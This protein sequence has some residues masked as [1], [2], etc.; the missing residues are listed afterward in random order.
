MYL[1]SVFPRERLVAVVAREWLHGEVNPF[2]TRQIVVAIEALRALVTLERSIVS[3][4][5]LRRVGSLR[6]I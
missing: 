4:W 1:E 5:L 2:V 3:G 6:A